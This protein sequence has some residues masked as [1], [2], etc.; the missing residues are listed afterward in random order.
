MLPGFIEPHIH[1]ETEAFK[2][3]V[4]LSHFN[5]NNTKEGV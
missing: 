3:Y 1:L 4:D 2:N 5:T